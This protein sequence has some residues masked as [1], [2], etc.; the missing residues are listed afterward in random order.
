MIRKILADKVRG[1]KIN[2][3]DFVRVMSVV[4]QGQADVYSARATVSGKHRWGLGVLEALC[5][6]TETILYHHITDISHISVI[7]QTSTP[8]QI[9][10]EYGSYYDSS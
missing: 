5:S 4:S 2:R 10:I 8:L 9:P 7:L 6:I 3:K 1:I